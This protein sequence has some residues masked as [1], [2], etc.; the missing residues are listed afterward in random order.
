MTFP[1]TDWCRQG[2]G[3]AM[4]ITNSF[5]SFTGTQDRADWDSDTIKLALYNDSSFSQTYVSAT[6]FAMDITATAGY[7]SSGTSSFW[8]T[9]NGEITTA[10]FAGNSG[11]NAGGITISGVSTAYTSSHKLAWTTSSNTQIGTGVVITGTG[12]HGGVI[13]DST[14]TTKWA[15]ACYNF[16]NDWTLATGNTITI[17]WPTV[18]STNKVL[19]YIG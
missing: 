3:N 5:S 14:T 16:G 11:Y 6:T 15:L 17:N 10:N 8:A 12:F 13:Y 1:S 7:A 18:D 4:T 19:F 2:I 9:G